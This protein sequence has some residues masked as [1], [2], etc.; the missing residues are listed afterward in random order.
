MLCTDGYRNT[1][2]VLSYMSV[3]L[4]HSM[5]VNDVTEIS[6]ILGPYLPPAAFSFRGRKNVFP[7]REQQN[8]W[9]K[10]QF[11]ILAQ[12]MRVLVLRNDKQRLEVIDR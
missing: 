2:T 4:R 1:L 12:N 6:E 5:P 11:C 7:I 3:L 9:F 10:K 8:T